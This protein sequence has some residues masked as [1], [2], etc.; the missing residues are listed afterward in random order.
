M[1]KDYI[2]EQRGNCVLVFGPL[3][4]SDFGKLLKKVPKNSVLS[5]DLARIAGANLAAGM[6]DDIKALCLELAPAAVLRARN[7]YGATGLSDDAI[8]WLALGERGASSDTMFFTMTGV[9]PDGY[10]VENR[11]PHP[12]D[13]SDLRRCLLLIEAVPELMTKISEMA[14]VSNEWARLSSSWSDLRGALDAESPAWRTQG[15][16]APVT[17]DMMKAVLDS[18]VPETGPSF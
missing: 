3:P 8:N 18:S 5:P 9:P 1:Q 14:A 4:L 10:R 11:R 17:Y 16:S 12:L 6:P 2:I 7:Q 13:P 15:G